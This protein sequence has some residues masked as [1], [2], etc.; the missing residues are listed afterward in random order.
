MNSSPF[1]IRSADFEDIKDLVLLAQCFPLCSLPKDKFKLEKKISV[2]K[3]SFA[4]KLKAKDRNYIFVME[5]KRRKQVIA[6]SQ[7]LSH[8]GPSRSFCY[9]LETKR[10]RPYL[11]INQIKRGRHQIG[12]LI[13]HP[14]YRQ[15]ENLFGLQIGAVRFLYIKTFPKE[16]SKIIEV[17]LTAPIHKGKNHFWRETGL[18]RL[19]KNYNSALTLFQENRSHFFSLFPKNLKFDLNAL[20]LSARNYLTHVH[21]ETYPVYKGLL[22]RGFYQT[23]R[24]HLLDGGIY[25]EVPWKTLSFLK[26]AQSCFIKKKKS[27]KTN[28]FL[29]SQQTEEGFICIQ[30]KGEIKNQNFFI[31]E[32]DLPFKEGKKALVLAFPF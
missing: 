22:K 4:K 12:G 20:S 23:N 32:E 26:S 17:S 2:S 13:L 31:Q 10:G 9:F 19:G 14:D 24:Y 30:T 18:K 7:I 27:L 15:S 28:S 25:L 5:D 21:P 6:T 29:V 3:K 11:K 16:F 1:F 8:F